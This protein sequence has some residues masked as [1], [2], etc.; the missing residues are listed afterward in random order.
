MKRWI[1]VAILLIAGVLLRGPKAISFVR[2][3]PT[4]IPGKIPGALNDAGL[5]VRQDGKV[6][7]QHFA[8]D[9]DTPW[10]PADQLLI[11]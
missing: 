1:F 10:G 11:R 3:N 5:L 7:K 2:E 8:V 6:L 9:G 4:S